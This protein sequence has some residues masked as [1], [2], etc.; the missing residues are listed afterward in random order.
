MS[1]PTNEKREELISLVEELVIMG[2]NKRADIWRYLSERGETTDVKT[3]GVYMD[4]ARR[5]TRNRYKK[6]ALDK[7]LAK[8]LRDLDFMEKQMWVAFFSRS[9]VSVG[10]DEKGK[11]KVMMKGTT[12]YE[13]AGI[14]NSLLKCK[15]RRA[16]LL[17]MDTE[18]VRSGV[19]K[20]LEDLI[21]EA[22]IDYEQKQIDESK[23]DRITALDS[24]QTGEKGAVLSQPDAK[25]LPKP[26]V[27]P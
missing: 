8:E 27:Q 21:A 7:V 10:L 20:T 16:K 26:S 1:Y 18:N 3:V 17:G 5:R 2:V 14:M 6:I 25:I 13:K 24:E 22:E 23:T 4:I 15:E 11:E 9:P 19:A 12:P